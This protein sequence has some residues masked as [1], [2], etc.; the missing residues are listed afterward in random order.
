M[1]SN[2]PVVGDVFEQ[3]YELLDV[4]GS[5]GGGTVFKSRQI[6]ADRQIALKILNPQSGFD[7]ESKQ[8]FLREA[9]AL[10]KLSHIN[11]VSVYHLGISES[12]LPYLA[13]ELIQGLSLRKVLSDSNRLP[14]HR[15]FK[16]MKQLCCAVAS[17]H[18]A[19]II[20]RDLKPENI[21]LLQKPDPDTVKIIDF[22]LVRLAA[23]SE[24][25]L[26]A[27]GLLLGSV[28]Y[29][30]PEQ[31]QGLKADARSDIYALTICLYEML[32]GAP[33]FSADTPIGLMYQHMKAEPAELQLVTGKL[34]HPAI[35]DFVRKGLEKNPEM[36]FQS[37]NEM[38]ESL[39]TLADLFD[40]D[41]PA[42]ESSSRGIEKKQILVGIASLFVLTAISLAFIFVK[43]ESSVN[44]SKN[45]KSLTP[46][47]REERDYKRSL[48]RAERIFG[49]DNM[50]TLPAISALAFCYQRQEKFQDA[51]ILFVRALTILEK[52]YGPNSSYV[53]QAAREL[54]FCLQ[55]ERKFSHAESC[56]LRALAIEDKLFGP[57]SE[58]SS[59]TRFQLGRLYL[60]EG[61]HAE[62]EPLYEKS[63]AEM[64]RLFG[65][66]NMGVATSTCDLAECYEERGAY[67]RAEKLLKDAVVQA[68]RNE[69]ENPSISIRL[70]A[71]LGQCYFRQGRFAESISKYKYALTLAQETNDQSEIAWSYYW[72]A[73]C[74]RGQG[75][76]NESIKLHK[77]AI[78][79]RA[80][81]LKPH[82]WEMG[83]SLYGLA[84]CYRQLAEYDV[85]AQLF[86]RCLV[87]RLSDRPENVMETELTLSGLA[88]CY[89]H[90]GK[91]DLAVPLY[92]RALAVAAKQPNTPL[93]AIE[94]MKE[95]LAECYGSDGKNVND[96]PP[97]KHSSTKQS[98]VAK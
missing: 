17:M 24:Q 41:A 1:T 21:M 79:I 14:A 45:D 36:R 30:S 43:H 82:D 10:N 38:S 86:Q 65:V 6:G 77:E 72:I 75:K 60:T 2:F 85:A 62:A 58:K 88:D 73:E 92:K 70:N 76:Y 97:S 50:K 93:S 20:H 51:E 3:R 9:Q 64:K 84:E 7:D 19:G 40:G 11:I 18:D 39:S 49:G 22:G 25:K 80:K 31:C 12:G 94:A 63:L 57:N 55:G 68:K 34:L 74:L 69:R 90:L 48:A 33:P 46:L 71:W 5:G 66:N 29:M 47:Q 32:S 23:A 26:T 91:I 53:A 35:R 16:I 95:G 56:Y 67:A 98:G 78:A 28:N 4:L 37:A 52:E 8:R 87:I 59:A 89:K 96:A 13:M 83:R 81:I 27:T 61:K 42:S 44:V 15:V 54:A